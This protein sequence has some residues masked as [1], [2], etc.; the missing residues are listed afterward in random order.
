MAVVY[1]RYWQHSQTRCIKRPTT[2]HIKP[3]GVCY[4]LMTCQAA[5]HK[6]SD[7]T[8][9]TNVYHAFEDT[10]DLSVVFLMVGWLVA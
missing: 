2:R 3:V 7:M 10:K 1:D 6:Q 5:L 8:D 9:M 4:Q